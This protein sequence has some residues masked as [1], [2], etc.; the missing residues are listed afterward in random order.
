MLSACT[1]VSRNYLHYARTLCDSFLAAYPEGRFFVLLV[2]RPDPA[3][4]V[5]TER[6]TA[7]WVE[8]IGI[9]DFASI[10][11]KYGILELNTCVKP[12]F[13]AWLLDRYA[14]E[15]LVYLDP[16]I[17][18]YSRLIEVEESLG[19]ADVVLT[20]HI[21]SPIDDSQRPA[22]QDFLLSGVYNLGF[23]AVSGRRESREFLDWWARRCLTL[24]FNDQRAGLFVDQKWVDLAPCLFAGTRILRHPGYNVAYWN[25]HERAIH[26]HGSR[27]TVNG[28]AELRCFH[29]SGIDL[30]SD[31]KVSKYQDRFTL[32]GR[33]DL[34]P[35]FADYRRAVLSNGAVES[36][37]AP[38]AFDRF[39]NGERVN[40]LARRVYAACLERFAG[41][42]PFSAEGPFYAFA[43]KAGLLSRRRD[44]PTQPARPRTGD[45]RVRTIHWTLRVL[46]RIVGTDRYILLMRYLAHVAQLRNQGDVFWRN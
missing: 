25:L 18:V 29:F 17:F 22:E 7:I 3:E 15:Q 36:A 24:G 2:D 14:L 13:L 12:T 8:D 39:S 1:I 9:P 33:A 43:A 26:Q 46:H 20:P 35:L 21:L 30:N 16:D 40:E 10:A 45:L 23:V 28:D 34:Q 27:R 42:D 4:P 6:F 37:R 5:R 19:A 38:Y 32:S 31:T 11:F 44:A 41:T